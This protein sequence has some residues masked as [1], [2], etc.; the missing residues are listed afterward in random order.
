MA[1]RTR[2][3]KDLDLNFRPHPVSGDVNIL[4][5][6]DAV[7]RSV[8][9]LILHNLYERPFNSDFGSGVKGSL[10]E[11]L[12]PVEVYQLR[13]NISS[14]ISRYEKRATLTSIDI[15][16]NLDKNQIDID[17]SFL[18]ENTIEPVT[19]SLFLKRVR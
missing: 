4:K 19:V 17:V 18:V 13:E 8:R 5:G 7:R 2:E 6:I 12:G 14:A 16:E 10:F 3:Y 15:K 1:A 9:N 11:N